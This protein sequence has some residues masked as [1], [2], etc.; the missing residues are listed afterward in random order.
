MM[1]MSFCSPGEIVR[2]EEIRSGLRLRRRLLSMGLNVGDHV[3]VVTN[4][5]FGIIVTRN[6]VRLAVGPGAARR[7]F[8]TPLS[9][10][11]KQGVP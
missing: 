7:V 4:S 6:G 8:V 9:A 11:D 10:N 5:P 2:I 1:P 3:Q